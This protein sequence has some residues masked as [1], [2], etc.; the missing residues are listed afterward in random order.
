MPPQLRHLLVT[1]LVY[2]DPCNPAVL[3]KNSSFL[4]F[5][6]F[7]H[8]AGKSVPGFDADEHIT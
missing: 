8:R 2:N 7:L 5:Y 6:D 1:I 4:Y 3:W